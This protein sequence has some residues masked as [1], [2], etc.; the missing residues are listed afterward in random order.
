M[1]EWKE[2]LPTRALQKIQEL[3]GQL[4]KL[5]KEKQQRQFQLDSLEAALQK[6]KQKVEDGKTE[7]ADLKRENQRLMEICENLEKTR[8]KLSHELQVKESQVNFQESQLSSCK[9]QIEKLEQELKRCK[10]EFERSQQSAEV[11]LNPCSTPQK[12]F[13]TP[14]TPSS[15]Y[16]DLKEKYN[17][18]V[19]DRKRLEAEVKAL[20][21]KKASLPVSQATM[22][23]R[24]IA[25][26]QASSSVFSWQQDKTPSRLSSCSL[27]TPL[28]R[29]VSAAH[30]LGEEV[31]PNKSSVQIGRGDCSGLP[32]DPHCSQP[33]H[34]AKA[35]NQ[36]LKSKMNELELRLRG[37][38]KEMK[39]QVNKFQELQLQL[40]KTKVDLIEKEKI[41]N[42]TRDEVVRT[43]A[44]YEQAA[45]KCTALE[46]K[47][48]NLTEE[49]SCHRQNAESAKR[50]LEQRVKEKEKE[51]REELSR[52]HQSFQAL[53]HEYTQMK[54]RLTQELQQAK[55]SLSV[56]QLELEKVTSVKQQLERSLEEIRHKFSRAEQALQ[57]SQ[58]TE[59]ELRRS[60]EEMKKENSLIRSQSEQ[61][62]R[63]ACRLEDEL[64]KVKV[65]LSQSQSFAEEMR[66]KNTSQEI[67][68]RDLQEKLNQQEN[69][70]TLEKLKLALADLEGQRDCSQDLL[71]KREHHIEQLNDKLNKI[72]K[73]F[74][75]L[76]SALELKRKNVKN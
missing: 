72:E 13:T 33:L 74:E 61:R 60:S 63:E 47:L 75:T 6:Q 10:S 11:S 25:R 27:R 50:S 1:E 59:N 18:E 35:Q 65:C 28:R 26:H 8:Q 62:T 64:G 38:E 56:L 53:D 40:E 44:Q 52:Q 71:K 20:H 36:E 29:D 51:L 34:Q 69:S 30:F 41:L 73:E 68:L 43:T 66:A 15:T 67:M 16:E 3:E 23:H 48:K 7:G 24:D 17:K 70:L 54:T 42:K 5:K 32:D 57:A 31:T 14:L 46:Q 49:L 12:L 4:D 39:D 21:A 22:N 9:K 55:H 19:E 58:L 2:G 45:A 37:Q 76:L